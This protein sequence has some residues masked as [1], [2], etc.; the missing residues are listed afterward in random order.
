M[1]GTPPNCYPLPPATTEQPPPPTT[2]APPPTTAAPPPTTQPPPPTTTIYVPPTTAPPK[3]LAGQTGTPPNCKT[4]RDTTRCATGYHRNESTCHPD[5]GDPPCGSGLWTPHA[6][7]APQQ[8]PACTTTTTDKDDDPLVTICTPT[9]GGDSGTR[10]SSAFH[11]HGGRGCHS[12]SVEHVTRTYWWLAHLHECQYTTWHDHDG[13]GCHLE[14]DVHP[15]E[16]PNPQPKCKYKGQIY[17]EGVG[18]RTIDADAT[19]FDIGRL[20]SAV[21]S[22]GGLAACGVAF[23]TVV[24]GII[25]G[26]VFIAVSELSRDIING[27]NVANDPSRLAG[28]LISLGG[29]AACGVAF[30][31]VVGGIICGGVFIAVSELSQEIVKRTNHAADSTPT[32]EAPDITEPTPDTGDANSEPEPTP[33][34]AP[35]TP[36]GDAEDGAD[37]DGGGEND[38]GDDADS[39]DEPGPQPNDPRPDYDADGDGGISDSERQNAQNDWKNGKLDGDDYERINNLWLCSIGIPVPGVCR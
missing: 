8:R 18:C 38:D 20:A 26:G 36:D 24:G 37:D 11:D 15:P 2:A 1:T 16:P 31:T 10:G 33:T 4:G 32:T 19:N 28:A 6:G 21:I 25:C 35:P 12:A 17:I 5:H 3:C 9:R 23:T 7:H 39:D 30:T 27:T 34:T 13:R 29:L 22:L 14:S